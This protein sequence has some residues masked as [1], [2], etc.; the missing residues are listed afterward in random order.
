MPDRKIVV[1]YKCVNC[2]AKKTVYEKQTEP[3]PS[4]VIWNICPKCIA[5]KGRR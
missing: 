2:G 1:T 3:I 5:N 4:K